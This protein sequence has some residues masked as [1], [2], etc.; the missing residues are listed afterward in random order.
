L[1][2]LLAICAVALGIV[3]WLF[4]GHYQLPRRMPEARGPAGPAIPH[5]EDR[6]YVEGGERVTFN[7]PVPN[8]AG[9]WPRFRGAGFDAVCATSLGRFDTDLGA[10]PPREVWALEVGEGYAGPAVLDG[11]VYLLDYDAKAQRDVVRCLSLETGEDIWR[12]SYPV[13]IKRNHGMSRTVPAVTDRH[14]VTIGPKCHVHGLDA[15]TG[16]RLWAIDMVGRWGTHVPPWY[17]GQCPLIDG[18]RVIL[19]P[20]GTALLAAVDLATGEVVW[21]TP[22]PHNWTMT[23]TSVMSVRLGDQPMF[24][25]AAS[26]GV[27]GV[28]P[29]DGSVLWEYAGWQVPTANAPS[30]VFLPPDTLFLTGGYNAGSLVLQLTTTEAGIEPV[31]V[32][33]LET[34]EFGA[35]QHTPVPYQGYLYGIGD[36]GQLTCL[37]RRGEIL[38]KSGRRT[39]FGKAAYLVV[40]GIVLALD[41]DG[42]MRAVRA[43]PERFELLGKA[44]VLDGPEAWGP[45]ACAGDRLLVRDL[46][47]LKCLQLEGG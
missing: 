44:R 21:E 6:S 47:V 19:A 22:N 43:T 24:V 33:R 29:D 4:G 26:G 31:A 23:H 9:A 27:V 41:D 36:D 46:N 38:W 34:S 2:P 30:P 28:S 8:L 39:T 11:R 10:A 12:Y 37:D 5:G 42:R 14:V 20:G 40:D 45:M 1:L 7:V 18:D 25:Y 13:R 17:T 15:N 32:R 3:L 35:H 16:E